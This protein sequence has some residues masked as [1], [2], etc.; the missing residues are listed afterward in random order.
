MGNDAGMFAL[1]A[2][3]LQH[4]DRGV[5]AAA[6]DKA[7]RAAVRDCIDRPGDERQRKITLSLA[8]VPVREVIANVISCEGAKGTYLVRV[9]IPDYESQ[10]LDFGV[11]E[12]GLLIFSENS[13]GNHRQT[14][15]FSDSETE[16]EQA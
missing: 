11:R 13:P 8:L 6:L 12:N 10:P 5:A 15:L 9:R 16:G 4:L 1:G 2:D 7:I 14:N 3:T